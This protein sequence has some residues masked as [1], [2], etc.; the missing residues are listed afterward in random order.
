MKILTSFTH[1]KTAEGDRIS[2]TYSEIDESGNLV[3]QNNRKNFV[4]TDPEI[5][6]HIDAINAY[7]SENKLGGD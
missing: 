7:I 6:E 5:K 2:F 1:H 4:V 3:S